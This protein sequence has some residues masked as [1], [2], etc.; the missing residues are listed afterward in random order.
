MKLHYYK[1]KTG[2]FGD[3]LNAWLWPDRLPGIFDQDERVVFI[4]IGTL[5]NDGLIERTARS[6]KRLVFSTGVGYGQSVPAADAFEQIYCLRG[7]LSAEAL[8]VSPDLAITDGAIL[9]RRLIAPS[10]TKRYRFAYMPHHEL[11]GEGWRRACQQINFGYIDPR[12]EAKQV[13]AEINQTEVLL[14]EAMHGAIIADALRVPWIPIV[15][16]ASIL[17]FKWNDWCRSVEVDYAPFSVAR[18][19]HP[20]SQRDLTTPVRAVRDWARQ[21]AAAQAVRH[22]A[23]TARP[24]LSRDRLIEQRTVQ[25]EE[26]IQQFKDDFAG[27]RFAD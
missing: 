23:Q 21:R 8:G 15:T 20:R 4:G 24:T 5:I 12:G 11:A 7:P 10:P 17:P 2:N 6:H 3:D 14:T 13:I 26:K 16:N 27:G 19:H 9:V 22:I 1:L 18:L 25:L